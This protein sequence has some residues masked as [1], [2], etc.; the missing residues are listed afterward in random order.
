M[1]AVYS[2]AACT[3]AATAAESSDKGLFFDRDPWLV[4]PRVLAPTWSA[5]GQCNDKP[6]L[7]YP[8]AGK[9]WCDHNT[10][11]MHCV[12]FAPLNKRGWVFQ[13]RHLSRRIMHFTKSQL[14]WECHECKAS[15]NYPVSMPSWAGLT[16]AG[17]DPTPLKTKVNQLRRQTKCNNVNLVNSSRSEA[18]PDSKEFTHEELQ[19]LYLDWVEWREMYSLSLVT[20]DEDKLAAIQGIAQDV[21]RILG[22]QL[23][24]GMWRN[25]LLED[26][27]FRTAPD[28][29]GIVLTPVRKLTAPSWSWASTNQR[30]SA[31]QLTSLRPGRYHPVTYLAEMSGLDSS[32]ALISEPL[33]VML[34]INCN[35]ICATATWDMPSSSE[36]IKTEYGVQAVSCLTGLTFLHTGTHMETDDYD[37]ELDNWFIDKDDRSTTVYMLVVRH[38][39][40]D[41]EEEIAEVLLLVRRP[42]PEQAF[43]RI[44]FFETRGHMWHQLLAEHDASERQTI[45]LV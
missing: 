15:E 23:L 10:I 19:D 20:K 18:T 4:R 8:L 2:N 6:S 5:N 29:G 36:I 42:V 39:I 37:I 12:E 21:G 45:R 11:W 26:L 32:T 1:Q 40:S 35:L 7:K 28:S 24:W 22:D 44:G 13:E 30:I 9:Y 17:S 27:C 34:H 14:F 38:S 3:I 41:W 25:R 43:E 16:F 33:S 31:G